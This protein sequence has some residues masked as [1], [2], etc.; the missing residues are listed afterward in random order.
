MSLVLTADAFEATRRDVKP[1]EMREDNAWIRSRLCDANGNPRDFD[2]IDYY[3]AYTSTKIRRTWVG[4]VYWT[5]DTITMG[6]WSFPDY[7]QGKQI[8]PY[9][10][11]G[12][13]LISTDPIGYFRFPSM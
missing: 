6:P 1:T 11:E 7:K 10:M 5:P 3:R 4:S 2:F 8:G 13:W 12:G 9:T